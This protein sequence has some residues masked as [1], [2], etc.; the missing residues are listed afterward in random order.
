MW[1]LER[2]GAVLLDFRAAFKVTSWGTRWGAKP[3]RCACLSLLSSISN[4]SAGPSARLVTEAFRRT[5]LNGWGRGSFV[6]VCHLFMDRWVSL[7]DR[8]PSDHVVLAE[9]WRVFPPQPSEPA[10]P[11]VRRRG[12]VLLIETQ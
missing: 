5:E 11:A 7:C 8:E 3:S 10:L 4:H 1:S 9:L 2:R 12:F 6:Q